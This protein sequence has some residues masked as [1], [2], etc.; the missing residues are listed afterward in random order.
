M[1][2]ETAMLARAVLISTPGTSYVQVRSLDG[3]RRPG[4]DRRPALATIAVS[5]YIER[6]SKK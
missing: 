6:T 2:R 1:Y 4:R 3:V 5:L